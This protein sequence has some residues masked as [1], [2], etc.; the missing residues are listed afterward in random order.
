MQENKMKR[1]VTAFLT[2]AEGKVLA[3]HRRGDPHDWGLPGGK[4]DPGETIEQAV[5][6]EVKE[7]TGLDFFNVKAIFVRAC[8]GDVDYETTTFIGQYSGEIMTT[9]QS[10]ELDEPG[11]AWVKPRALLYGSFA[12][13]NM[14]LYEYM[15][16]NKD[17]L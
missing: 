6:R 16:T 8:H 4:V 2:N 11:T 12:S 15:L 17:N 9:I 3:V 5:I 7:E 14:D 13:Y 10:K 1:A